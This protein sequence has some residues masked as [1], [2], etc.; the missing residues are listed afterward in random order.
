VKQ[1]SNESKIKNAKME[2][3]L[4]MSMIF[5]WVIL[6]IAIKP[7]VPRF[8]VS[9]GAGLL[10][11]SIVLYRTQDKRGSWPWIVGSLIFIAILAIIALTRYLTS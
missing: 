11:F 10:A 8:F 6:L 4:R 7:S 5:A 1:E 9:F 2:I 3:I